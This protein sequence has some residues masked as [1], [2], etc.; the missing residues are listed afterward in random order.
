MV[1]KDASFSVVFNMCDGSKM[2][3]WHLVDETGFIV[4]MATGLCLQFK[5]KGMRG[6]SETKREDSLLKYLTSVAREVISSSE[7]EEKPSLVSCDTRRDIS[8]WK[9]DTPFIWRGVEI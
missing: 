8:I 1:S 9:M 7:A 3:K 5:E 2:Q 6:K 4:H